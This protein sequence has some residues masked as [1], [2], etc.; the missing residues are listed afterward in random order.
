MREELSKKAKQ[1]K[2][3]TFDK[4]KDITDYPKAEYRILQI[5]K[6]LS[7]H[8]QFDKLSAKAQFDI[9]CTVELMM[10]HQSIAQVRSNMPL[11]GKQPIDDLTYNPE[12]GYVSPKMLDIDKLTNNL[13]LEE[14]NE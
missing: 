6:K 14:N 9:I 12:H 4:L 13:L 11:T 7:N 10:A 3:M 5:H 8:K 1:I 2:S